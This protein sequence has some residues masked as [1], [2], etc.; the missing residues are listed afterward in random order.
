MFFYA[1]ATDYDGTIAEDG[2][3][4]D[5][6]FEALARLRESGRR[7][8]LATGR[9]IEDLKRVCPRLDMFEEVVAENGGVIYRPATQVVDLLAEPPP[10]AFVNQL[11]DRGVTPL[12]VGHVIVATWEPN[13]DI[14]LQTVK[15]LGLE[16]QIIFN[17]GAVMVLPPGIN[18]ASGLKAA[19]RKL[20]LASIN[21]VGVGDA[22][23]DH[24][25]LN[26]C[27]C[28]VA[29]ANAVPM[30]KAAADW[31]TDSPR[32][33]GV[34][35]VVDGL[36]NNDLTNV[37]CSD[38][39][40]VALGMVMDACSGEME[41]VSMQVGR[42]GRM[43]ICGTSG[44]GKSTFTQG[45]LERLAV[46]GMQYCIIDPEG[47]YE[48]FAGVTCVGD[49]KRPPSLRTV[50][51]LLEYP[52]RN[53]AISL[54]GLPLDDRPD[55]LSFVIPKLID[56]RV[57]TGRPHWLVIDEAHHMMPSENEPMAKS[58]PAD[59]DRVAFITV[60]PDHMAKSALIG[61]TWLVALGIAI[62]D[63]VAKFAAATGLA[64]PE[65]LPAALDAGCALVWP[66]GEGQQ[67]AEV[68]VIPP[69]EEH[70][71]HV[72]K[73]ATGT[74]GEDTSFY[75][76]GPDGALNL[77]AQN[78]EMFCQIGEGVDDETWRHHA[79]A[80][81]YSRWL[82]DCIKDPELADEIAGIENA[83]EV[84]IQESRRKIRA[85]IERRYTKAE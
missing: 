25:L 59:F 31:V 84:D 49:A 80:K 78:L 82:R 13:Q 62:G 2:V 47:D 81:D 23:N 28:S 72:R 34:A 44:S 6:T 41:P 21:V 16:L 58:L 29:V 63:T 1:L 61:T 52:D 75:F 22:E 55:F 54:L 36:L 79:R 73:Y 39:R 74:L 76:R 19:L 12:S 18:K 26:A 67:P 5:S 60:H 11:R 46:A 24:A 10:A 45:F 9:E 3:V 15:D 71:R 50:T 35:E 70:R 66:I 48:G 43:L 64:A 40:T 8:I 20:S 68:H 37:A 30:L 51:E 38:R 56:L 27:G 14:V 69:S 53:V 7:L 17:K 77:R 83:A 57:R 32:G 42:S 85:A 33:A 65:S 4:K